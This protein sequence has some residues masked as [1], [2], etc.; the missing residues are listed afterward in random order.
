MIERRVVRRILGCVVAVVAALGLVGCSSTSEGTPDSSGGGPS[1]GVRAPAS[2]PA[3]KATLTAADVRGQLLTVADLPAGWKVDN[4][5][6]GNDDSDEPS[7]MKSLESLPDPKPEADITFV[8]GDGV[9]MLME[10]VGYVGNAAERY[11]SLAAKALDGCTNVSF[12]ADGDTLR[13]T[14]GAMSFPKLRADARAWSMAFTIQG[15]PFD[16]DLVFA[17]KGGELLMVGYADLGSPDVSE[18]VSFTRKALAK[19]P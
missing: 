3:G 10:N 16:F 6:D 18:L 4:S 19:L 1:S 5:D 2:D 9:P 15:V 14:I 13:G 8:Q 17:R 12:D 11:M 7:C